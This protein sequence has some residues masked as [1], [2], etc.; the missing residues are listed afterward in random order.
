M[1]ED[2]DNKFCSVR[3]SAAWWLLLKGL[4]GLC[5]GRGATNRAS[6]GPGAQCP[7][8]ILSHTAL[9][10]I[11]LFPVSP[12]GLGATFFSPPSKNMTEVSSSGRGVKLFPPPLVCFSALFPV[13][14]FISLHRNHSK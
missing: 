10:L 11:D 2:E 5:A 6:F 7:A 3:E 4:L 9:E 13:E 12:G 1:P 14:E 8:L